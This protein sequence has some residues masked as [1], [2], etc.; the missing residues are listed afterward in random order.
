MVDNELASRTVSKRTVQISLLHMGFGSHRPTR[1]PLLNPRHRTVLLA[2]TDMRLR[3][4]CQAQESMNSACQ[5][6]T[7][8]GMMAQSRSY[9]FFRGTDWDLWC[10]Y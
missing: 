9:V 3:I 8:H 7:E 2:W 10:M 1:V 4:W 6:G 5:V